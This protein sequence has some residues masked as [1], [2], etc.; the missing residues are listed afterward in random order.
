[1]R[2]RTFLILIAA[3]ATPALAQPP[4]PPALSTAPALRRE[5]IDALSQPGP[6]RRAALAA[7]AQTW[8]PPAEL[9]PR[10]RDLAADWPPDPA[11][12]DSLA[13][14]IA[15]FRTRQAAAVLVE[16]LDRQ[17]PDPAALA[18][19][20]RSSGRDDLATARQWREWLDEGQGLSDPVWK[21]RL[22]QGVARRGDDAL[23]ARR[24]LARA[25][26]EST[27][28][29][30]FLLPAT[31]DDERSKLLVQALREPVDE[32]CDLGFEIVERELAAGK[33]LTPAVADA[34]A[35]SLPSP[36]AAVR[37][38]AARVL[39]QAMTAQS[40]ARIA[41][42]LAIELDPDAAAGL[43]FAAARWPLPSMLVPALVW[44]ERDGV[45]LAP[46]IDA[47]AALAR[48]G[49][50]END[51]DRTR[52]AARLR[53]ETPERLGPA[54]CRLLAQ[55][56]TA[57]D[58]ARLCDAL[59]NASGPLAQAIA[60]AIADDPAHAGPLLDAAARDPALLPSAARAVAAAADE[61]LLQ[62]LVSLPGSSTDARATALASAAARFSP[63][64]LVA[65]ARTTDDAAAQEALLMRL[66]EH[67]PRRPDQPDTGDP[68]SL[69]LALELLAQCRLRQGRPE[70]ALAALDGISAPDDADA[71]QRLRRLRVEALVACD[72]L[73][74]ALA[75]GAQAQDWI[76]GL[77]LITTEPHARKTLRQIRMS[78]GDALSQDQQAELDRLATL[79][80]RPRF[81]P[82]DEP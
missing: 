57:D 43:L 44:I 48:A 25:L 32:L 40:A 39:A 23:R 62:R 71:A 81:A 7:I 59:Q 29:L 14:A 3:A 66:A 74:D 63:A 13:R 17:P 55:I 11:D 50:L 77:A 75:L 37:A 12:A 1:M 22:A 9:W 27:R 76:E 78:F 5:L 30:Y 24:S 21:D 52:A 60:E 2:P 35:D 61:A 20:V 16:R 42:A 8:N 79:I 34:V 53:A 31:P 41:D 46:G 33:S 26:A 45:A 4:A 19:L 64:A 10:V 38:R 36:R 15:A 80:L 28:R 68:A 82:T 65:A 51:A 49:A 70:A 73:D 56:G 67:G 58:R 72:R 18:A 6:A 69:R 54:G 47:L